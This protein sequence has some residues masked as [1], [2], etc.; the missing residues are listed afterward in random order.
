MTRV[1]FQG[2]LGAYSHLACQQLFP[3]GEIVACPTFV[4]ALQQVEASQAEV[5]VIPL[6]N[7]TAGRVEEIYRQVPKTHLHIIAEHFQP[8]NPSLLSSLHQHQYP[9]HH[10]SQ[11]LTSFLHL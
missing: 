7:S 8:V 3:E 2:E 6:E 9:Y 1:V 11:H 10:S 5:A 4:D